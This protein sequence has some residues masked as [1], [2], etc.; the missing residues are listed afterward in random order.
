MALSFTCIKETE[1]IL[2]SIE[3]LEEQSVG[4]GKFLDKEALQHVCS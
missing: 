2:E 3:V 4:N 1:T